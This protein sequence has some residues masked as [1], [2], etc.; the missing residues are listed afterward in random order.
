MVSLY[1]VDESKFAGHAGGTPASEIGFERF[2]FANAFEGRAHCF[3]DELIE[4][5][6]DLLISF[7]PLEVVLPRAFEPDEFHYSSIK[8]CLAKRPSA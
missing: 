5:F 4:S 6:E 2:G 1:S 3:L 7:L 8:A